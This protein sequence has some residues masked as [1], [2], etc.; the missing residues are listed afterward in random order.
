MSY[1]LEHFE[2]RTLL[3][4]MV[5]IFYLQF[6]VMEEYMYTLRKESHVHSKNRED[7]HQLFLV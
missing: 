3:W 4:E 1:G 7:L 2:R 6:S 5:D